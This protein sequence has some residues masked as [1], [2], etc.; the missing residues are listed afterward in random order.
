MMELTFLYAYG[1]QIGYARMA[2]LMAEEMT[3]RGVDIYNDD[4]H[5]AYT[6]DM[7]DSERKLRGFDGPFRRMKE[8]RTN[9][10][11]LASVPTHYAGKWDGQHTSILTMWEAMRLPES[12]RDTLHEF[13]MM[14]VPSWHN[15][16]LFGEYHDNVQLLLLGVDPTRWF[17]EPPPP[18]GPFFNFLIS[19]AG[20]IP[21]PGS[22]DPGPRKGVD[23]AYRAFRTVFKDLDRFDP[24]PRLHI[25]AM[26]GIGDY[27]GRNIDHHTGRLTDDA[28]VDL[29]R[30]AHCYVQPSRGE[31]FGL[32]PLQ[33]MA[34]GLPT[35]LTN[36][37]GHESY[38]HLGI[39]IGWTPSKANYFIYGD[40]GE[41]WEPNLEEVCEAMWD[42]YNNYDVHAAKAKESAAVI[43]RDW[44]WS[45]TVD[46]FLHHLGPQMGDPYV[47]D[48]SWI[49]AR[50]Q[51]YKIVTTVDKLYESA[52]RTLY[53]RKGVEYWDRADIKRLVFENGA[54]DPCCLT[55]DDHGLAEIQVLQLDKY[56]ADREHCPTCHQ[57]LNTLPTEADAIF[58]E[59]ERA[60]TT[61]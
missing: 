52:G 26:A 10:M 20:Q 51:L 36:A 29:Y 41:W 30:S 53:F 2:T 50:P 58:E 14:L 34:N 37:H 45:N 5:F 60:A 49:D 7:K 11:C 19:G 54:L 28:E 3:R 44:T 22:T 47:G 48:G 4:G 46:T 61:S 32:Q 43:A 9:A 42:V 40:A 21:A 31:G 17:Y 33:A 18:P 35:I 24:Q 57:Q 1:T 16:D 38:A 27:Y 6:Q 55:G 15:R 56:R 8:S 23:V 13:D 25:K 12:F 59:L 39:P